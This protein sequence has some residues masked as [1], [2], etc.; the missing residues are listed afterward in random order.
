M[1]QKDEGDYYESL[2]YFN[3]FNRFRSPSDTVK[4]HQSVFLKYFEGCKNVIS[5]G[6]GRGEFIECLG[7]RGIGAYGIDIDEEMVDYCNKRGLKVYKADALE[8]LQGLDDNSLDGVFTDDFVEHLETSYLIKLI[9]LC[10]QKL[11]KDRYMVNVTVNPLSWTAY[12]GVYLL[13]PTHKRPI[14][15]ES[16]RF[17]MSSGGFSKVDIELITFRDGDS[18]LKKAEIRPNMDADS[19]RIADTFNHNVDMLNE[20]VFGPENYAAIGKK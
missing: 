17:Y 20:V 7:T 12:S 9:R 1:S 16:M 13:D 18:R 10:V 2:Q 19:K 6:C 11:V 3:F 15:P 4:R 8:H 5:I 14:H